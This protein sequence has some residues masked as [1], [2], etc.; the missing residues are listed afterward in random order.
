L[1]SAV[2]AV[3]GVVRFGEVHTDAKRGLKKSESGGLAL[4][5]S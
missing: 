3:L 5:Q 1:S 4:S 2:G